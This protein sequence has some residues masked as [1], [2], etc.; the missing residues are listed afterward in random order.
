MK[1]KPGDEVIIMDPNP[2][3]VTLMEPLQLRNNNEI[4]YVI[5]SNDVQYCHASHFIIATDLAKLLLLEEK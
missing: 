3:L 2:C 1:F 5:G 4:W